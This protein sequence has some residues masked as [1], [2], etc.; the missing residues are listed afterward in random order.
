MS[1]Q[2]YL[3]YLSKVGIHRYHE[4][5]AALKQA[6]TPID[7][8]KDT[9]V[10]YNR[11]LIDLMKRD[12]V[13]AEKVA[14]W[15]SELKSV[16]ENGDYNFVTAIIAGVQAAGSLTMGA[17]QQGAEKAKSGISEFLGREQEKE[18]GKQQIR[19][20][21]DIAIT[22][23]IGNYKTQ[24][25]LNQQQLDEK[26]KTRAYWLIGGAFVLALVSV[27]VIRKT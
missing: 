25:D 3:K 20:G 11:K 9:I 18:L 7:P 15:I 1:Q 24:H 27:I 26:A 5:A 16:D 19:S 8:D 22:N 12:P 14:Y 23:L 17:L 2:E 4:I 6:G 21:K 10:D 13:F